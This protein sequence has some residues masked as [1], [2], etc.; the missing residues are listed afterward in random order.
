VSAVRR[1]VISATTLAIGVLLIAPAAAQAAWRPVPAPGGGI[2][3]VSAVERWNAWAVNG[4]TLLHYDR[5]GWHS[6]R[7]VG[8]AGLA[9][10]K[11]DGA[12]DGW[13]VGSKGAAAF[14]LHRTAAGWVG[15]SLAQCGTGANALVGVDSRSP[16]NA[17]AV[18]HAGDVTL[19]EHWDGTQWSVVPTPELP[20]PA[21]LRS[22]AIAGPHDVWAVGDYQDPNAFDAS[23]IGLIEHWDGTRW[24]IVPNGIVPDYSDGYQD[25]FL[26]DVAVAPGGRVWAVGDLQMY[27]ID[28]ALVLRWNGIRWARLDVPVSAGSSG[29]CSARPLYT[30]VALK[31]G[32]MWAFGGCRDSF[33]NVYT[34]EATALQYATGVLSWVTMP[35]IHNQQA[36][37]GSSTIPGTSRIWSVGA[38][39]VV[40]EVT[41]DPVSGPYALALLGP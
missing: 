2:S 18:G 37:Y 6:G 4:G 39:S 14:V 1:L 26:R 23:R 13:A 41:G 32:N 19:A 16:T 31:S 10:I 3:A 34:T 7:T 8:G 33:D 5:T 30:A 12:D 20:G 17:W 27:H 38:G 25:Y 24:S 11:L 22:I 40:D 9:D 21:A 36:L 15:T 29:H 28:R 35:A